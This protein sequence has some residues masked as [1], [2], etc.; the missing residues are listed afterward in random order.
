MRGGG[1][2]AASNLCHLVKTKTSTSTA[3]NFI[4][5]MILKKRGR[6]KKQKMGAIISKPKEKLQKKEG[7]IAQMKNKT[8]VKT[9]TNHSSEKI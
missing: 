8:E 9:C 3:S 2:Q 4:D 7:L 1:Y 5:S 6:K